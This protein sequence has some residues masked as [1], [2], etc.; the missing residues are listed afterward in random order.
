MI[1]ETFTTESRGKPDA[2]A[3]SK[4]FPGA[5]A[6]RTLLLISA[7]ATVLRPLRLNESA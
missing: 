1:W 7:T 5:S 4:T 3:S 2:R 6:C